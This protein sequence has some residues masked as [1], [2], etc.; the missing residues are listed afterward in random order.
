MAE[1]KKSRRS[2]AMSGPAWHEGES[3][4]LTDSSADTVSE[5][6]VATMSRVM[7][8]VSGGDGEEAGDAA[9]GA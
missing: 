1:I 8:A 7:L 6:L 3:L 9:V 2:L 4:E 5:A